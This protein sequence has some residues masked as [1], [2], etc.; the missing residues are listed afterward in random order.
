MWALYSKKSRVKASFI[1]KTLSLRPE[2]I[3]YKNGVRD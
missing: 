1:L 3:D 2:G